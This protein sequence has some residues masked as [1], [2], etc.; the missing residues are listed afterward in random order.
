MH[1]HTHTLTH[2][3]TCTHTHMHTHTHRFLRHV[4]DGYRSNPYHNRVHTADVLQTMH[5]LLKRGGMQPGYADPLSHMACL[6]A[7]VRRGWCGCGCGC[8]CVQD[9]VCVC[10]WLGLSVCMCVYV[11]VYVCVCKNL[12]VG[13]LCVFVCVCLWL[14]LSVCVYVFVVRCVFVCLYVCV[15]CVSAPFHTRRATRAG[16]RR[17]PS[18]KLCA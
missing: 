17:R 8:G 13:V 9:S 2:T 11:C 16:Q 5:V 4:E 14:G 3:H 6:L 7:A 15:I 10:V 12:Y 1:T 18:I